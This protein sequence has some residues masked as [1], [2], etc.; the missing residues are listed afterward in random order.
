MSELT[1]LLISRLKNTNIVICDDDFKCTDE[2]LFCGH[3]L[4]NVGIFPKCLSISLANRN[5]SFRGGSR[6][7][8]GKT[9]YIRK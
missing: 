5:N 6:S 3:P 1:D 9:K 8:G 7:K 4:I 2:M